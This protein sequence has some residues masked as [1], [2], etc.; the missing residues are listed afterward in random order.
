MG[1]THVAIVLDRSGSMETCR[2]ATI[3]GFN[4][5]V[6][7]IRRTA[8]RE[9]VPTRVTLTTFNGDVTVHYVDE[10]LA[11]LKR[12]SYRTYVPGGNTAMLDA[13]GETID[14][15]QPLDAEDDT[16]LVC[17]ISDG[18][19]NASRRYSYAD[20]AERIQQ[21]TATERWTFTYLG[22]NQDLSVISRQL[23]I[24]VGNVAAYDAD[25]TGTSDAWI[26]HSASTA[27]YFEE[28]AVESP[29]GAFY[30]EEEE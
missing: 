29:R 9:E 8:E 24:P 20:I 17:V 12:L 27:R 4:E 21:L 26:R 3:S 30:R 28:R 19:E 14:R 25:P 18:L 13:V 16:F 15:L 23:A 5:Y 2:Q 6:G 22:A 7:E 11:R 1:T 10:P